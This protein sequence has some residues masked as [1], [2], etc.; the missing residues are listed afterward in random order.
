MMG[1]ATTAATRGGR[2][3][4]TTMRIV[5]MVSVMITVIVAT[6]AMSLNLLLLLWS[7]SMV[8]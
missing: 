2:N 1:N 7:L 6:T 5:A 8:G 3:S 4:V